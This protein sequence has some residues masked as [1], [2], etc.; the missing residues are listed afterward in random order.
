MTPV[1]WLQHLRRSVTDAQIVRA[2]GLK[3]ARA[4]VAHHYDLDERLYRLFLDERHAVLLRLLRAARHDA[5]RGP[6]RQEAATSPPSSLLRPG[7]RVLDIG[8]GWGGLA[9]YLARDLRRRRSPASRCPA[10][11]SRV[12]H[13]ARA[14]G[15]GLAD[16]VRFALQDY[17]DVDG[18]LRPHR[19]G[20]HVRARRRRAIIRA[21]FGKCREL[22]PPDGVML[23]ALDRPQPTAPG[24]QPALGIDKYIF[25]GGYIPALSEVMPG[26]RDARA[27]RHRRRD[28]AP[29]LRR[30]ARAH[31]RQRFMAQR[32]EVARALR[33]ALLPHVGVL[34]RRLR[35]RLPLRRDARLPPP[36]GAPAGARAADPRLHPRGAA[37]LAAAERA[38]P[39]YAALHD[40][41]FPVAEPL[42]RSAT[43]SAGVSA[44]G[45]SRPQPS[46]PS[47]AERAMRRVAS[48]RTRAGLA[49]PAIA[50]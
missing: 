6:A 41:A 42:R 14:R 5:G 11:S 40:D 23:A 46:R 37:R 7:S 19:L 38:M 49:P 1:A 45:R 16:R 4:N 31:W 2:V 39:D 24:V 30:D 12:A 13:R 32:E 10:S 50:R 28:P 21:Y 34:S 18:H 8:C 27:D 26:D 22:L 48:R 25:P 3:A 29:A 47:R 17:R 33:R 35:E 20:R 15:A 44:A 36:V 9:L 43:Q